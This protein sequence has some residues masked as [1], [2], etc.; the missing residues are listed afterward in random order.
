LLFWSIFAKL[1]YSALVGLWEDHSDIEDGAAYAL[2]V[3]GTVKATRGKANPKVANEILR[4]KLIEVVTAPSLTAQKD[5]YETDFSDKELG[6]LQFDQ[7]PS[8]C[9]RLF[10]G[11]EF[12]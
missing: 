7:T 8:S 2:S 1:F 12:L 4:K 9:R 10:L 5:F 3:L 6:W 11:G